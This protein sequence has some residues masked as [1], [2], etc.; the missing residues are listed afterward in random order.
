MSQF[1]SHLA[2]GTDLQSDAETALLTMVNSTLAVI[3]FTTE[4]V[5][6]QAND[7]FLNALEYSADAIVGQHH[8]I[9]VDKDYAESRDYMLFWRKLRGGHSFTDQFPRITRTGRVIW[10]QA[11]YAPVM[12][13]QNVVTRIVKVAT[14]VTARRD[15]VNE[16]AFGLEKMRN[17]DLTH[18]I[19]ASTL[20][21]MAVLA[22]ALNNTVRNWSQMVGRVTS[23][24]DMVQQISQSMQSASEDLSERTSTQ[25][26]ALGETGTAVEQLAVTLRSAAAEAQ[27]AS[28]VAATIRAGAADSSALVEDVMQAMTQIQKSSRRI[29]TIVAAMDEIAMQTNLLALN[30]AIE[31][32]RAGAAG[33]GFAVVASEVRQ[34]AQRSAQSARDIGDLI[35]ESAE[36][37]DQ[38][39][40]LVNRAGT[41]LGGI[42]AGVNQMSD[43]IAKV[44]T[45]MTSQSAALTQ[46]DSAIGQ[47]ERVTAENAEM[48]VQTTNAAGVLLQSSAR[49]GA[50]MA[51]FRY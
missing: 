36:Q 5:I 46:I 51:I 32:A 30:A 7:N 10:I 47:L 14:D 50:E 45:D 9:F 48:V 25:T 24:T 39:V 33:R 38:G 6:L 29:S 49:L 16:I 13:A 41:D 4:G 34:L 1:I 42:F 19:T 12:N 44:A 40:K 3:H 31:A 20:P 22:Q 11:T 26:A 35:I 18:Q 43:I 28:G 17:G 27:Q 15:A 21:D 23:V 2:A 8:R 37:V